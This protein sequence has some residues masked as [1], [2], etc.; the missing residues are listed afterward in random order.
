MTNDTIAISRDLIVYVAFLNPDGTLKQ[1]YWVDHADPADRRRL[2]ADCFNAFRD[3]LG[4][5]TFPVEKVGDK[6]N[7]LIG[8]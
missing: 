1:Q 3:G 6:P 2:G 4:V 7:W 5:R 8:A